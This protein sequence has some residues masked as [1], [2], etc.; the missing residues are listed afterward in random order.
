MVDKP[1]IHDLTPKQ[2]PCYRNVTDCSYW[3]VL[4]S[5]NSWNIIKLSHKSTTSEDCEDIHKVVLDG[6]SENMASL[7]QPVIYDAM[8]T[9]ETSTMGYYVIKF[10][11]YTY[12]L[13]EDTSCE[14]QIISAGEICFKT[15]YLICMQ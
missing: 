6:I 10:V 14:G 4:G 8:N 13:Q 15:K 9:I 12:T 1:W 7:V 2:K 5:F 11:S 3:P